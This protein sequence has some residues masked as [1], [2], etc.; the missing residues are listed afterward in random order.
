M[1][2]FFIH[3]LLICSLLSTNIVYWVDYKDNIDSWSPVKANTQNNIKQAE[4]I[5]KY[6]IN[7]K[8]TIKDLSEKYEIQNSGIVKDNVSELQQMIRWL[9]SIQ[10]ELVEKDDATELIKSVVEGLKIVNNNLKPYLKVKQKEYENKIDTLIK[11]YD[12]PAKRMSSQINKLI[13][14]IAAPMQKQNKL[15][16]R[17]KQIL[18]HLI[19]LESDS[20]N[21]YSFWNRNFE[22]TDEVK[23][24]LRE[25]LKSVRTQLQAIK[26]LL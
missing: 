5:E 7:Y 13:K 14:Q 9:R 22:S 12:A 21:L 16:A 19:R 23:E 8:S 10:T 4:L 6:L 2:S 26:S 17:Q 18:T 1:R 15:T 20:K 11:K 25:I 3:I 24:Y